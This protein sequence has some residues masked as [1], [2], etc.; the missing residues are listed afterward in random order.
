MKQTFDPHPGLARM[1]KP[2][3]LPAM[4]AEYLKQAPQ[5]IEGMFASKANLRP[6]YEQLYKNARKLG[7][8]VKVCPAKTIIPFYRTHVFAQVKPTTKTRIDLSFALRPLIEDGAK[9]PK[10]LIDTGGYAKK[11]RLT[12][13]I[14][15][16]SL[17]E[18][19]VEVLD[20]LKR[21]YELNP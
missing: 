10:R 12:H 19:D 4:Q 20:W 7:K 9:F 6:I 18:I 5:Y 16:S 2:E 8:D 17:E 11:D 13:R 3:D 1:C 14:E 21:S 15:I